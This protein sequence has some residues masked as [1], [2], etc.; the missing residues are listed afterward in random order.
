M[1]TFDHQLVDPKTAK[2]F[3]YKGFLLAIF[4]RK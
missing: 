4:T 3:I 1:T 2:P